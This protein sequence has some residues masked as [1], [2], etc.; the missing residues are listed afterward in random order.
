MTVS[1]RVMSAGNGYQ[2]LLKSVV[3]RRRQPCHPTPADPLLHRGGHAAGAL[4]GHGRPRLRRRPAQARRRRYAEEQLALLLGLGRDPITG[5]PLGRAFP[6]TR[7]GRA[8]RGS[9]V[10]ELPAALRPRS[11]RRR[12]R[13]SRPRSRSERAR[14]AVAGYD[15]T[16]SVPK[17]VS[18]LWGVADAGTQALIVDAHHAAVA[19]VL[20]FLERE[21]A[22]HAD[23]RRAGDGAVAQADIVGIAATAYDHWDSR[24]ATRS[25][26]PTS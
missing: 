16:F 2:Y 7:P 4:A 21:V 9:R 23:G 18:V 17:S 22:A 20:D 24:P 19:E 14:R 8:D 5:D 26:T 1:M 3:R 15:F 10:A 25:C 13:R 11:A 12:S 6:S